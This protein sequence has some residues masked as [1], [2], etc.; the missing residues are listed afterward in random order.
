MSDMSHK[1]LD[2]AATVTEQVTKKRSAVKSAARALVDNHRANYDCNLSI[3]CFTESRSA[4]PSPR[5]RALRNHLPSM[6]VPR[7]RSDG[8]SSDSV[9]MSTVTL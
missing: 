2:K 5:R 8:S 7:V 6:L 4:I 1:D 9:L 3:R